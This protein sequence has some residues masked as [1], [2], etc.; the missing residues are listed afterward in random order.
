MPHDESRVTEVIRRLVLSSCAEHNEAAE[1][2]VDL[3]AGDAA[4]LFGVE[5][6][7]DSLALVGL[8]VLPL[9]VPV[10]IFGAGMLAPGVDSSSA[11]KLLAAA[12]LVLVALGPFAAG[13]GLRAA[14]E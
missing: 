3:A 9:S 13:A 1:R 12:S 7:L 14:L 11:L 10:L 5:R 6:V 8:L 2:K 4:P